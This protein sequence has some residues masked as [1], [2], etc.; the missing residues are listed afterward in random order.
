MVYS[1]IRLV[2]LDI[3]IPVFDSSYEKYDQEGDNDETGGDGGE[4]GEELEDDDERE[5]TKKRLNIRSCQGEEH[6]HICYSAELFEEVA[7]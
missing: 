2:P 5:E 3:F 6:T 7:W 4:L 1:P